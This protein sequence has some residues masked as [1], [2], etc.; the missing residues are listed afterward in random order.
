M[1]PLRTA[2]YAAIVALATT[3]AVLQAQTIETHF[4]PKGDCQMTI[5]REL[6]AATTSI[7][8]CAYHLNNPALCAALADA[9]A[10]GITV[11]I[12][13]DTCQELPNDGPSKELKNS[14]ASIKTDATEKMQHNKYA[15]ID[16]KTTITGSYNWSMNAENRNAENLIVIRDTATAAAFAADFQKHW[17]HS[18]PFA[19]RTRPPRSRSIPRAAATITDP[20]PQ[21]KDSLLWHLSQAP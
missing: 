19:T 7:D 9:A 21:K 13:L 8:L 6:A 14:K 10:R 17:S 11:R 5:I 12:D 3:T 2:A 16:G 15:I 20:G 18:R 4:S 1:N